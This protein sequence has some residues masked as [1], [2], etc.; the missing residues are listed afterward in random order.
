MAFFAWSVRSFLLQIVRLSIFL[1]NLKCVILN[2]CV[3]VLLGEMTGR[4]AGGRD[5]GERG[6]VEGK[7]MERVLFTELYFFS[8]RLAFSSPG[9]LIPKSYS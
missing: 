4:R 5:G 1:F 6:N 2:I 9:D 7:G 8:N 3:A